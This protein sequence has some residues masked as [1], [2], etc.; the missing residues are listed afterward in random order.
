MRKPP[1]GGPCVPACRCLPECPNAPPP[2]PACPHLDGRACAG[3]LKRLRDLC[4]VSPPPQLAVVTSDPGHW[5]GKRVALPVDYDTVCA[6]LGQPE[7]VGPFCGG[8]S[9]CRK[10]G[11]LR[12]PSAVRRGAELPHGECR[13]LLGYIA[14]DHPMLCAWLDKKPCECPC[15]PAT[16]RQPDTLE[17]DGSI[18]P[19]VEST[20]VPSAA[21]QPEDP[22]LAKLRRLTGI[23]AEWPEECPPSPPPFRSEDAG[24]HLVNSVLRP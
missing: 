11:K 20:P 16:L 6:G 5:A 19:F 8:A 4:Y 7:N 17:E 22:C 13:R 2:P 14:L 15:L 1:I 24:L 10:P 21:G 12:L 9:P 3:T 18:T 23:E